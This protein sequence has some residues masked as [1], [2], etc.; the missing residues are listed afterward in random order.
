MTYHIQR[1]SLLPYFAQATFSCGESALH[2][3]LAH[4]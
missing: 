4:H 1:Q 2:M 3:R